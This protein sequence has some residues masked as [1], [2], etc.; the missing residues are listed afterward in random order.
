MH[1]LEVG[2]MVYSQQGR[3]SGRAYVVIEIIDQDFVNVSDGHKRPLSKPKKKNIK[4]LQKTNKHVSIDL[5]EKLVRKKANN[6]QLR[7][8]LASMLAK[9]EEM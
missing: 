7:E 8:A 4:H 6:R 3:D 5:H 2:Q 1:D 9:V